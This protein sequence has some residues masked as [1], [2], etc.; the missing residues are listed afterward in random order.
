MEQCGP[1]NLDNQ[2]KVIR[3]THCVTSLLWKWK[4]FSPVWLFVTP[5][6]IIESM[7]FFRILEWVAFPFSRG[8]SQSRDQT[9]GSHIHWTDSLPAEPQVKPRNAGVSIL[10]LLQWIF[11]AQELNQGLLHCRRILY[12]LSFQGKPY[13]STII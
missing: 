4:S 5:W 3:F 13:I 2:V 8:S 10:S 6:T 9:Q 1:F 12:Q 11:P 7:E